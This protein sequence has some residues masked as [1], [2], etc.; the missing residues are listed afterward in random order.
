MI[1]MVILHWFLILMGVVVAPAQ[2][3]ELT[4]ILRTSLLK[5]LRMLL[6][7][8][9]IFWILLRLCIC[10]LIRMLHLN[11]SRLFRLLEKFLSCIILLL[12]IS[13]DMRVLI[14]LFLVRVIMDLIRSMYMLLWLSLVGE[15]IWFRISRWV[16]DIL[17]R[18][19]R[20][21]SLSSLE[22]HPSL[23]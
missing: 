6:I 20:W 5:K 2:L 8:F 13:R 14:V 15:W 19:S 9:L 3:V 21:H 10:L 23:R 4:S 18:D 11:I 1:V 17:S 22:W 7:I 12:L 16:M